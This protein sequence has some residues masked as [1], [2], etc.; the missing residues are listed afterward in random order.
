MHIGDSEAEAAF[1]VEANAWLS[2]HAAGREPAR[3]SNHASDLGAHVE[4]CRNW[5]AVLAANGWAG[6][7]WPKEF[8]GRGGT[9]IQSAVFAEEQSKFDVATG[10]F[11]VAIGM[12]GPTLMAHGSPD[13]QS[14]FLGP[15]LRGEHVWCQ[16]FSEPD[17]GSDLAALGTR[18][19]LD[20]DYWVVTGQKVWTSLGQFADYAILLARTNP[21]VPKHHGIT[22]F[23]LDMRTPG[24]EVRPLRQ[25][26]GV[27]H[28]NEVF[29]NE[30]RIPAANVV[31][32]V[33][34]GWNVARTTLNSERAFIGG[35]G[36]AWSVEELIVMATSRGLASDPTVRQDLMRAEARA[37]TLRFLGYRLR[38]AMSQGT[39]PG[40]EALIMKLAYAR[41]W[42]ATTDVAMSILGADA[43]VHS[44]DDEWQHAFLSQYAIRL[45]GGT[46]E[47][48]QNIIGEIGLGLPREPSVDR[49]LPWKDLARS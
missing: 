20:G 29:L 7:T 28:F 21:D 18:A 19:D 11:A 41:H 2:E 25:M 32:D 47:V 23:L 1:R 48:Q 4:A 30:V 34:A 17:A 39:M 24:I 35:G 31:G 38:T 43:T 12:A 10:S 6:I 45:G 9:A 26:T 14:R 33:G 22:Y 44:S 15:M 16:L 5:Q 49:D 36:N 40:R 46:D 8:G 3:R 37:A 13:Q 42:A 27:A